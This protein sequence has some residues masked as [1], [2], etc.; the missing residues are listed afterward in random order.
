MAA[1]TEVIISAKPRLARLKP[2]EKNSSNS[3]YRMETQ[4]HVKYELVDPVSAKHFMTDSRDEAALAFEK[5]WLVYEHHITISIP[6]PFV[7]AQEMITLTWNNN[8]FFE[9]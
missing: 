9:V 2:T 8:P 4:S 3:F 5:E 7:S 6:S 1:V